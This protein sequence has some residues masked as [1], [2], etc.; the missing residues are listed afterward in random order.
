[1][2]PGV[3]FLVDIELTII[4]NKT[5]SPILESYGILRVLKDLIK[6]VAES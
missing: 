2:L 4:G 5:K 3:K 6:R 1:M